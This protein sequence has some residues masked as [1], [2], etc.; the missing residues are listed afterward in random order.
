MCNCYLLCKDGDALMPAEFDG[1]NDSGLAVVISPNGTEYIA[2]PA[3]LVSLED[4]QQMLRDRRASKL[5]ADGYL[6][7]HLQ[8]NRWRVWHPR[9][10]GKTGGYCVTRGAQTTCNCPDAKN[11]TCKHLRGIEDLIRYA[12]VEKPRVRIM[13]IGIQVGVDVEATA[14]HT[15]F[16]RMVERDFGYQGPVQVEPLTT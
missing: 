15:R 10:H 3:N 6:C 16:A 13:A 5:V 4:A 8:G 1:F 9:R 11:H 2:N 12:R 14:R 7:M